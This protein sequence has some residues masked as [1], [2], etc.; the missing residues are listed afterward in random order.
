MIVTRIKA[1]AGSTPDPMPSLLLLVDTSASRA[2][3]FDAQL[4]LVQKLIER[5]ASTNAALT[6]TVA[7]FDQTVRMVHDGPASSFGPAN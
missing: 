7:S 3:G 1:V 6:L 4:G 5:L 2:L